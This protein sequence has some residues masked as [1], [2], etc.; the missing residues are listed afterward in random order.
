MIRYNPFK[1]SADP[2]RYVWH[3]IGRLSRSWAASRSSA[4][5]LPALMEAGAAPATVGTVRRSRNS[6]SVG[7]SGAIGSRKPAAATESRS[8]GH[9]DHS[10]LTLK[11]GASLIFADDSVIQFDPSP[12]FQHRRGDVECSRHP[13]GVV[14]PTP[15]SRVNGSGSLPQTRRLVAVEHVPRDGGGESP[16]VA[17]R[18]VSERSRGGQSVGVDL[19]HVAQRAGPSGTGPYDQRGG[20]GW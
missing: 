18:H 12:S 7:S 11:V 4:I 2:A 19:E 5:R 15:R 9:G 3:I 20:V 14:P 16:G 13:C 10:V 1:K 17:G 8:S 6:D